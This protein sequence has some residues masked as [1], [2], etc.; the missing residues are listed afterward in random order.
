MEVGEVPKGIRWSTE[1]GGPPK[2]RIGGVSGLDRGP[3][4]DGSTL[5]IGVVGDLSSSLTDVFVSPDL[6]INLISIGQLIDNN[7]NVHFSRSGCVV[8][9]QVSG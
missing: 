7:C 1:A 9:D 6:S 3:T 2:V 8:Q 5:P 4:V